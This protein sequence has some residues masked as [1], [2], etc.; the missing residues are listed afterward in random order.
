MFRW[1]LVYRRG[2]RIVYGKSEVNSKPPD[3]S[4]I[5]NGVKREMDLKEAGAPVDLY[6]HARVANRVFEVRKVWILVHATFAKHQCL[7]DDPRGGCIQSGGATP[8]D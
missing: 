4:G 1:R 6:P 2:L 5:G 8:D 7:V 3:S